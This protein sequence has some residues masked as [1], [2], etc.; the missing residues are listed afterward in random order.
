MPTYLT[1]EKIAKNAEDLDGTRNIAAINAAF[2]A[3]DESHLF[4]INNRFNVTERA[5]RS[6]R[7]YQRDGLVLNEGLEYAL[8]LDA[9]IS[10][11]V[12]DPST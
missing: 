2:R 8:A 1:P 12:N 11:I 3:Q 9:E 4:P 5:I 6:L 10:R 7:R